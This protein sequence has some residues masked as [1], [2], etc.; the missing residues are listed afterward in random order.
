MATAGYLARIRV[1]GSPV[2]MTGEL[3]DTT[4]GRTYT[5]VDP[6]RRVLDREATI[7]V[8]VGGAPTGEA[9]TLNRLNGTVTF[10]MADLARAT[11]TISGTYLTLTDAGEAKE[12]S[13]SIDASNE[14][15]TRFGD[16]FVRRVQA[17]LD[18]SG[19]L[20]RWHI[21]NQFTDYIDSGNP[22]VIEFKNNVN[23][24]DPD[25]RMWAI[26]SSEEVSGS[27]DGLVEGS[28][29]FETTVDIDNRAI[30]LI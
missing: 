9:Y 12:Y 1:T 17:Q 4:D 27:A 10:E 20:S 3:T 8:L 23:E 21:D 28:I 14:D 22:M 2:A 29:D 11:V 6:A 13:Y 26:L 5:I 24:P 7:T 18:A 16:R 25:L 19:S 15:A 30:A